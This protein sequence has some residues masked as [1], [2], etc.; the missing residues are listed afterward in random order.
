MNFENN[1]NESG[2]TQSRETSGASENRASLINRKIRDSVFV[3]LF[4]DKKYVLRLY[5]SLH[6][7]ATDTGEDNITIVTLENVLANDL[8]ND[9]GFLIGDQ[10][11]VLV[12]AQSTWTTNIVVRSLLYLAQTYRDYIGREKMNLYGKNAL[13]LPRPELY[14]I[15][16]GNEPCSQKTLALSGE[17]FGG[18]KA[19]LEIT[20]H[21]SRNYGARLDRRGCAR[22]NL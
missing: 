21:G 16:T 15:Y 4:R 1:E 12:E 6:P 14:V 9:L 19:D 8:Y 22:Y 17:F 5:Q 18:Q 20:V 2:G 13:P 10:L 7:E 3:H 11:I